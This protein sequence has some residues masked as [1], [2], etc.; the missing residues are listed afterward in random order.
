[1]PFRSEKQKR[2]MYANYPKI[3]KR[4]SKHTPKG[5]KLPEEIKENRNSD[6]GE[7]KSI[8]PNLTYNGLVRF[9]SKNKAV[10]TFH[11]KPLKKSKKGNSEDTVD[12][13]LII[14]VSAKDINQIIINDH[15]D[16][17]GRVKVFNTDETD[18]RN[19][20]D[21]F[22]KKIDIELTFQQIEDMAYD[23]AVAVVEAKLAEEKTGGGDSNFAWE[24]SLNFETLFSKI[25]LK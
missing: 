6:V 11:Y 21:E 18:P 23:F 20:F 2:F 13:Q 25:M 1:M 3:A 22:C 17:H 19:E 7:T 4:W 15:G 9:P 12:V 5:K 8:S 24:E 10:V 14:D 16:I